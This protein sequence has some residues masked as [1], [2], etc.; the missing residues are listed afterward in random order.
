VSAHL[1]INFYKGRTS[2][3]NNR[4]SF[5][6][7]A[8]GLAIACSICSLAAMAQTAPLGEIK[9][10]ALVHTAQSAIGVVQGAQVALPA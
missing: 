3:K 4:H 8:L 6:I 9:G 7:L 5:N 1:A 10:T 2:M